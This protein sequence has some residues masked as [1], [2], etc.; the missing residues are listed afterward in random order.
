MALLKA[1]RPDGMPPLFYQNFWD[2]VSSDVTSTVLH[3]LNKGF[4]PNSLNH[5][6]ITLILK[7][8]NL[9]HVTEYRSISLCNVLY[10]IFSKILANRLKKVLP[11][12]ISNHQSAFLKGRLIT[13]N[14]L[15]AF[16]TLHYE[17]TTLENQVL[18]RS[19]LT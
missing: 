6:F 15:V 11:L 7:T 2:L 1:P 3:F 16:K 14:I 5:T 12:I 13:D 18:W 4:L 17:K 8:K 19:S 10:N 9:E